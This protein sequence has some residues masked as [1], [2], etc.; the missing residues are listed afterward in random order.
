MAPLQHPHGLD[1]DN[2]PSNLLISAQTSRLQA[3][4]N[5]T[6]LLI[7]LGKGNDLDR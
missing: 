2:L 7:P 5:G 1:L 3:L 4:V 6:L